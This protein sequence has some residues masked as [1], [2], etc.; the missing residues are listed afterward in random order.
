[1]LC[2][3][4][5]LASRCPVDILQ[6]SRALV[7]VVLVQRIGEG[8]RPRQ[9]TLRRYNILPAEVDAARMAVGRRHRTDRSRE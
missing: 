5:D 7:V 6:S 2:D 4:V 8:S 1:L 3:L 9:S